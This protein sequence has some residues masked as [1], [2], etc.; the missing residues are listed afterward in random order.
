[1]PESLYNLALMYINGHFGLKDG[2]PDYET[3]AEYNRSANMPAAKYNLGIMYDK[4]YI[5][6][7]DGQPDYEEAAK[8]YREA[9]TLDARVN[10]AQLYLRKENPALGRKCFTY[11]KG[12][13]TV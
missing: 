12:L 5:G 7:K 13:E 2:Q 8:C 10:L 4:G 6:A 1:M 11:R 3:A 9:D